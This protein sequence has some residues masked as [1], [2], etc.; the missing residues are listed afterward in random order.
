M[1][2]AR[3]NGRIGRNRRFA[4]QQVSLDRLR[5]VAKSANGTVNDV[6][7]TLAGASLRKFLL[8]RGAL[9]E[10]P[11]LAMVPV[12]GRSK[13]DT[14][15]GNAVGAMLASLGTDVADPA[16]RLHA[17]IASTKAGKEQLQGMSR[18][19]VVQFGMMLFSP[20]GLQVGTGL[21]GRIRPVFNVVVSNVPGPE[22]P[23]YFRGARLE[24][25]YPM[26]IPVHG[27]ALNIT[28]QS[29]NG[30]LNFGFIA[31]RDTLPHMQRIAVY[32]GEALTELRARTGLGS[33]R[34]DLSPSGASL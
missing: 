33:R 29:Y 4:T 7:L 3:F 18:E 19:A 28:C 12:S 31:C 1:R 6:V 32:T 17:V 26:S 9:P 34:G 11:L 13:E 23:L 14:G 24:A 30:T 25:S 2:Q 5:A 21:V 27:L 10:R 16:K 22:T 8:E 20:F 15:G